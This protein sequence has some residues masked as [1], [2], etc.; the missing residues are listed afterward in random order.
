MST[1]VLDQWASWLLE[2]RH[3]GNQEELR[4]T[5]DRLSLVRDRVL[6][7]AQIALGETLL[8]VG[9]GDGLIALGALERVGTTGTVIFSEIS[10]D[11]LDHDQK[12]A[13]ELGV[14]ERCRF[15]QA[16]A[17]ELTGIA[18]ESVD[19]VT[20]RSVL[21]YV[22]PKKRAFAEFY[23]VLKPGGRFSLY[24]PVNRHK[25]EEPEHQFFGF[26]VSPVQDLA[27]KVKEAFDRR[28]PIDDPMF[29][30]DERDLFSFA[31]DAGFGELHLELRMDLTRAQPQRWELFARVSMNPLAPTLNEA[32]SES[33]TS[34]EAEQ[35]IAYLKP[36]VEQGAGKFSVAIACLSGSK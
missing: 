21:A 36:L 28:Q 24:E 14:A 11:L 13:L 1:P 35:F 12:L 23:R 17:D 22:G 31:N 9:T 30:Y 18:D 8:D 33:L 16:S 27:L 2:R 4:R 26:D 25:R 3:G 29:D 5:L 10:R 15:V 19:V 34:D 20:T 6:D 32:I 7:N